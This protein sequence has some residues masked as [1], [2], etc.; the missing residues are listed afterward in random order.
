MRKEIR[1]L[2][3][4]RMWQFKS[5]RNSK[6]NTHWKDVA[7]SIGSRRSIHGHVYFRLFCALETVAIGL[8]RIFDLIKDCHK[9]IDIWDKNAKNV[10]RHR[11]INAWNRVL[12]SKRDLET[13]LIL[14]FNVDRSFEESS[15][16][17][18][19]E[20]ILKKEFDP[21]DEIYNTLTELA[22][23]YIKGLVQTFNKRQIDFRRGIIF[24]KLFLSPSESVHLQLIIQLF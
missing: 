20:P 16:L 5:R 10:D 24:D 22:N 17:C 1:S 9:F 18:L 7:A 11:S 13:R 4:I 6:M 21:M 2:S 12:V 3:G 23:K 14:F 19:L 15:V 8:V